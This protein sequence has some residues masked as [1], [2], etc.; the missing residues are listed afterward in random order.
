VQPDQQISNVIRRIAEPTPSHTFDVFGPVVEFLR[1]PADTDADVCVMWGVIPPGVTVPLHSH[2]D[3][4]D[5]FIISGTQQVLTQ[6]AHGLQWRDVQAGDY[7]QVAG[8]MLHAHRNISVHPA[9]ELVI[10]TARLGRFFREIARPITSPQ[11]PTPDSST[12]L[13]PLPHNTATSSAHRRRTRRSGYIHP[14]SQQTG[15]E[16]RD[17][18]FQSHCGPS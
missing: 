16:S 10:T 11:P 9:I 17:S 3:A 7:V 8:G 18:R 12:V 6:G 4:E 13:S 15:G 2:D 5:F 1:S 14:I